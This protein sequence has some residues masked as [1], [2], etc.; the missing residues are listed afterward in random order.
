MAKCTKC[1]L[2]N[3]KGCNRC[4]NCGTRFFMGMTVTRTYRYSA[5]QKLMLI[6]FKYAV[7]AFGIW[8]FINSFE[9]T[10]ELNIFLEGDIKLILMALGVILFNIL[11]NFPVFCIL[12]FVYKL[13]D[14]AIKSSD[15]PESVDHDNP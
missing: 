11:M 6:F 7:L 10:I 15:D 8:I 1:G 13:M 14:F 4:I 12:F 3:E 9:G 2:I 5:T